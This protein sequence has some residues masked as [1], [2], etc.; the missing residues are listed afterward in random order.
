LASTCGVFLSYLQLTGLLEGISIEWPDFLS[1]ILTVLSVLNFDLGFLGT[2][3]MVGRRSYSFD[4]LLKPLI[5]L[6]VCGLM[7]FFWFLGRTVPEKIIH[8]IRLLARR[9]GKPPLINSCGFLLNIA[10]V[11]VS[12]NGFSVVNCYRHPVEGFSM[13]RMPAVLCFEDLWTQEVLPAAMV[14]FLLTILIFSIFTFLAWRSPKIG[15]ASQKLT[16][17]L[18]RFRP[19]AYMWNS[20]MLTRNLCL[21]FLPCLSNNSYLVV[22][23][24]TVCCVTYCGALARYTPWR[25]P[26]HNVADLSTIICLAATLNCGAVFSRSSAYKDSDQQDD[27]T[28]KVLRA[29]T[30]GPVFIALLSL[31]G[32]FAHGFRYSRIDQQNARFEEVL[33]FLVRSSWR[34]S[35]LVDSN[36]NL[37]PEA[38]VLLKKNQINLS[39]YDMDAIVKGCQVVTD[40]LLGDVQFGSG[41]LGS[42]SGSRSQ[43]RKRNRVN[44]VEVTAIKLLPNAQL[45]TTEAAVSCVEQV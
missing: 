25:N 37:R 1:S 34:F 42:R 2:D 3:C 11:P 16:F 20:A 28:W 24:M 18:A 35:A 10:F 30:I 31:A 41:S 4:M 22:F 33:P 27:V 12:M 13:K 29:A 6:V 23:L 38:L 26:V 19:E 7:T 39:F 5:V 15:K 40:L 14:S 21:S 44:Q 9:P 45:S 17:L 43:S 32:V 8:R 36:G